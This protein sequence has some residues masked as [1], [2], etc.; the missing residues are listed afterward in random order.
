MQKYFPKKI[1][2][3]LERV[4]SA[5]QQF[6][7]A[8]IKAEARRKEMNENKRELTELICKLQSI[9]TNTVEL[10]EII[11]YLRMGMEYLGKVK[12]NWEFLVAFFNNIQI[13]VD[14]NLT[15]NV[16]NFIEEAQD[17]VSRTLMLQA[18]LKATG[19]CIQVSN[20]AETYCAVSGTFI[21]PVISSIGEQLALEPHQARMKQSQIQS[22]FDGADDG[23]TKLIK[24]KEDEF[25]DRFDAQMEKYGQDM[26]KAV[27][28]GNNASAKAT[29]H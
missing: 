4:N 5:Q 14:Q 25:K 17:P 18:A 19:Y 26:A 24:E 20:A 3:A 22:T 12:K 13:I 28:V 23:V 21:M 15:T 6:T 11:K 1:D 2:L 8:E 16:N 27:K 7:A 10:T 9:D 29:K